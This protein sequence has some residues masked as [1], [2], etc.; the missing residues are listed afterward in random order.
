[1]MTYEGARGQTAEEMQ[2]VFY[3][4]ED[5]SIRRSSFAK[6]YNLLNKKDKK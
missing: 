5:H 4:P 1:A 2:S 6:I 3:F